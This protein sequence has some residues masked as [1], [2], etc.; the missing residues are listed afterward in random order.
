LK[1]DKKKIKNDS[2]IVNDMKNKDKS[3]NYYG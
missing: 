1:L 3:V 2:Q